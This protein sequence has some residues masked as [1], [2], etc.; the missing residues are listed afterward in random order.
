MVIELVLG[1][2]INTAIHVKLCRLQEVDDV[3]IKICYIACLMSGAP[4]R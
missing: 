1:F 4:E 3:V 2:W